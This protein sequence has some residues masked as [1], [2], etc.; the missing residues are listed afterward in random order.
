MQG[1]LKRPSQRALI[2]G[3]IVTFAVLLGIIAV[4]LVQYARLPKDASTT[5]QAAAHK[6]IN[7]VSTLY[8]V[9][10]DETPT[11]AQIQDKQ[12][13]KDPFF[14]KAQ[15][16]DYVLVYSKNKLA[17]IYREKIHKL[18]HVGPITTD[19]QTIDDEH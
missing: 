8:M 3:G 9:P 6:V 2:I 12:K 16:G 14:E 5:N 10:T 18:V 13:L 17:V 7:R 4:L 11:I 19:N 15:N 1:L